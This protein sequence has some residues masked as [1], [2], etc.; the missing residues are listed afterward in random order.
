MCYIAK[1]VSSDL[2]WNTLAGNL[3]LELATCSS[4]ME[5]SHFK[6]KTISTQLETVLTSENVIGRRTRMLRPGI[7]CSRPQR[8]VTVR[9]LQPPFGM[10][11][12]QNKTALIQFDPLL[13]SEI[14]VGRR[15]RVVRAGTGCLRAELTDV[16]G[17]KHHLF[18]SPNFREKYYDKIVVATALAQC[19]RS[20]N[21]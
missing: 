14:V 5:T 19:G 18:G 2:D 6:I 10:C 15:T 3:Q 8:T 16:A 13:P 4:R 11:T 9:I 1:N 17:R 21:T 12:F 20:Q 7:R